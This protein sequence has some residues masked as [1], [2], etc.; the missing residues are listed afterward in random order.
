[1]IN[2]MIYVQIEKGPMRMESH[3]DTKV[4]QKFHT[5]RD[6]QNFILYSAARLNEWTV[7]RCALTCSTGDA[8]QEEQKQPIKDKGILITTHTNIIY[9]EME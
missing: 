3:V 5:P 6:E 7:P 2:N 4:N 9:N 8:R 1:M